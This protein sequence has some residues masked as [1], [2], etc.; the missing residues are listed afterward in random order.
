MTNPDV[1]VPSAG[2]GVTQTNH[3]TLHVH[4][5]NRPQTVSMAGRMRGVAL[6]EERAAPLT[7]CPVELFFGPIGDH[8]VAIAR[9]DG[10]G[11]FTFDD[12]PPG[13]YGLRLSLPGNHLVLLHNL[14]VYPGEV[15]Q[16]RVLLAGLSPSS[17]FT[18][19]PELADPDLLLRGVHLCETD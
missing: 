12:L 17:R 8:P 19:N 9:T 11:T 5:H 7:G 4:I 15:C 14:R 18:P 16:P 2:D 6:S 13:F 10:T 3:Q 1:I